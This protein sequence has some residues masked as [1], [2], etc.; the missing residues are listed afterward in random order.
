MQSV[1][2]ELY[3]FEF[4]ARARAGEL[5]LRPVDVNK[6]NFDRLFWAIGWAA[7]AQLLILE[8]RDPVADQDKILIEDFDF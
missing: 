4:R 6:E 2:A 1:R 7:R 3:W 8:G 5:E